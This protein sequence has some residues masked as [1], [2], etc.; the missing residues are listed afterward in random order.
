MKSILLSSYFF[1][2]GI[3][4]IFHGIDPWMTPPITI[5][6]PD[7]NADSP[8][9]DLDTN[10]NAVAVWIE[11]ELVVSRRC[12][13]NGDWDSLAV[14]SETASSSPQVV[15]DASSTATA[16]W[17]E[18]GMVYTAERAWE[19]TWS[20]PEVLSGMA[21]SNYKIAINT[22]GDIVV[23][24]LEG[25]F[26]QVKIKPTG[27]PWPISADVISDSGAQEPNISIGGNNNVV[28]VWVG[29]DLAVYGANITIGGSW[30]LPEQISPASILTAN[31]C[32]AVD[33]IGNAVAAWFSFEEMSG[34]FSNVNVHIAVWESNAWGSAVTVSTQPPSIVDPHGLQ[35]YIGRFQNGSM[36][37]MWT[38]CSDPTY[39][40]VEFAVFK[41]NT[42]YPSEYLVVNTI[43][44]TCGFDL[45]WQ[46]Y[47]YVVGTYLNPEE[48]NIQLYGGCLNLNI[49]GNGMR[50]SWLF[51]T[52]GNSYNNQ[53]ATIQ[54]GPLGQ[55]AMIW[56]NWNGSTI[57]VQ[58][59]VVIIPPI[60]PPT[61]AAVTQFSVDY[62]FFEQYNNE[63]TWAESLSTSVVR[64]LIYRNG[65]LIATLS[66]EML[67]YIDYNQGDQSG[68]YSIIAESQFGL[69]SLPVEVSFP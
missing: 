65:I 29:S 40:N 23:V 52:E 15:V 16:I 67:S 10:G 59:L 6:T 5:S 25:G 30:S 4:F 31:P 54:S 47:A 55:G 20:T 33:G 1:F 64:Y 11:N 50:F 46:N 53:I 7:I 56:R 60:S 36:A 2:V 8:S 13:F 12:P 21:A 28:A 48:G 44:S 57:D 38:S 49:P 63:L 69:S 19:G 35:L 62:G 61:D 17:L 58:A 68:T 42:W 41:L 34:V 27:S 43:P 24:W 9:I 39:Y 14:V 66:R 32:V 18:N 45:D 22:A 51:A 37:A 26:V 3:P